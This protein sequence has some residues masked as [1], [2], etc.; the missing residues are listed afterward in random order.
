MTNDHC[1]IIRDDFAALDKTDK[2]SLWNF[3]RKYLYFSTYDLAIVL[4]TTAKRIRQLKAIAGIRREGKTTIPTYVQQRVEIE[5]PPD[6]D[7]AEWWRAHYPK[8]GTSILARVTGL[9]LLTVRKRLRKHGIRILSKRESE[10]SKNPL[11]T[12]AWIRKHY[13]DEGLSQRACAKLAGISTD[14]F[15]GWLIRFGLQSKCP[16]SFRCGP[17]Y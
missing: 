11:C 16:R 1:Q 2:L 4:K 17:S 7:T 13:Y 5:L 8:Y 12:E 6:W 10:L 15:R 14:T 3:F 9:N